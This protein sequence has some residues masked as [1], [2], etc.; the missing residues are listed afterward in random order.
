MQLVVDNY[1]ELIGDIFT[2][3]YTIGHCVSQCL[4]MSKGIALKFKNIFQQVDI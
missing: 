4:Y 2:T 3:N 1:E